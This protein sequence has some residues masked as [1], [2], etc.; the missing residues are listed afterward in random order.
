MEPIWRKSYPAHIPA[1]VDPDSIGSLVNLIESALARYRSSPAYHNHGT[2]LSYD[3][4]DRLSRSY[5]AWL[6]SSL[7]LKKGDRI[8]LMCPNILPFPVAMYGHLR[9]GLIQV[10]VNPM[11]TARELQHQLN[12]ARVETVVLIESALPALQAILDKVPVRNVVV[13][14]RD[15]LLRA[16][17]TA[18]VRQ[19]PGVQACTF[20]SALAAG[21]KEDYIPVALNGDDLAFLQYTGGTT[22]M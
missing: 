8:A 6:Q 16:A 2:T 21:G 19:L 22:G 10:N 15:D 3:D 17:D 14:G 5:A 13:I 7:R 11:Y 4:V 18:T 20:S 9:A 12:D 1:S